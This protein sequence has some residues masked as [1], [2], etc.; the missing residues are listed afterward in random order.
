VR[1]GVNKASGVFL[2]DGKTY[3]SCATRQ[4]PSDATREVEARLTAAG[5]QLVDCRDEDPAV[6]GDCIE[7]AQAAGNGFLA[8]WSMHEHLHRAYIGEP[9]ADG[10]RVL[11][12]EAVIGSEPSDAEQHFLVECATF[13]REDEC[14]DPGVCFA[15][16]PADVLPTTLCE[17]AK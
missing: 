1:K 2:A 11:Q 3:D 6:A 9:V 16:A 12:S 4:W 7:D 5:K 14:S 17:E 8:T 15:C 13:A 10:Y